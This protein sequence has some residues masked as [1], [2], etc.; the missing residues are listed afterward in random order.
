VTILDAAGKAIGAGAATKAE[1]D[2]WEYASNQKGKLVVEAW[3]L[4]GNAAKHKT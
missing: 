3:D 4:A 2:W 1:G